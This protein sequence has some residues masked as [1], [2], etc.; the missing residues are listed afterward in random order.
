M[1]AAPELALFGVRWYHL[2][3]GS[4]LHSEC[5][6]AAALDDEHAQAGMEES[7]EHSHEGEGVERAAGTREAANVEQ[8]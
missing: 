5:P 7:A 4:Q 6:H 3:R 2:A 1:I 8:E